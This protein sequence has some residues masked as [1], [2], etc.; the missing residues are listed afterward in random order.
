MK[1]DPVNPDRQV[2][3]QEDR[4]ED[5]VEPEPRSKHG[6]KGPILYSLDRWLQLSGGGEKIFVVFRK[7]W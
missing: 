4:V 5:R 1:N 3:E 2:E 6:L 7:D